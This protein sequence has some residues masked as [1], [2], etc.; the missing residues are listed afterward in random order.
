MTV[1]DNTTL[2]LDS[3]VL[4]I[5]A[6]TGFGLYVVLVKY[7][8]EYL[9]R[10]GLLAAAFGAAVPVTFLVARRNWSW[11]KFR[12]T[13]T[14]LL[15]GIVVIRSVT[16]LLAV[17]FTLA[18]YV[19]LIDL[20]VPFFTPIIAA[21]LLREAMPSRTWTALGVT[22]LGSF[23]VVTVDPFDIQLPNGTADLVGVTFALVSSLTMAFGVVYT[24]Y[25]TVRRLSPAGI[26]FQQVFATATTYG[27]LS[28]LTDENWQPFMSLSTSIWAVFALFI[29]LAIIGGGLSQVF[30]ISRINA[31]LFSMLLSWRLVVAVGLGWFLLG[32]RLTSLW[33]VLG[34]IIVIFTITLYIRHQAAEKQPVQGFSSHA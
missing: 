29:L 30:A 22:G 8:I 10:F 14:W 21:L 28:M 3:I 6:H 24:R 11:S 13:E 12:S 2:A 19:Q 31:T 34:M 7:L 20:S 18:T 26:F 16:K 32:E 25:L 4:A 15:C 23:L 5:L 33:Q 1:T 9:P 17:Q 27:V